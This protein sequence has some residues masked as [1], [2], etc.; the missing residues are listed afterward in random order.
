MYNERNLP[1]DDTLLTPHKRAIYKSPKKK[2]SS[3]KKQRNPST[4][5]RNVRKSKRVAGQEYI[6]TKGI[7]VPEKKV[8][9]CNCLKCRYKCN[10]KFSED[11]RQRIFNSYYSL[12][13]HERQRDFI[14]QMVTCVTPKR[15]TKSKRKTSKQFYLVAERK[16]ERVCKQFFM[17]TLDIGLR[18]VEYAISR[19][20]KCSYEGTDQR[21]K[22]KPSN[23]TPDH[24]LNGVRR[25]IESFPAM[26]S[27]YTR[28]D[29]TKLYLAN[30]LSIKRMYVLYKAQCQSNLL[31]FVKESKYR[32]IF[33]NE[34]NIG[35][36][37]PKKD[38]CALCSKYNSQNADGTLNESVKKSYEEHI[39]NKL[40]AR[41]EKEKDKQKAKANKQYYAAT[42]DLQAVL[43][44][45]CSLI[46]ELYY[47]RKLCCF[48]LS[49]YSL[50][51]GHGFCHMWDETQG[52]RGANE[53]ATCLFKHTTSVSRS[54]EQIREITYYSD[55]CPGQNRNQFVASSHL[56]S[57]EKNP[58]LVKI[59][60]KFL[61]SG[62]SQLECDSIHATIEHAKEN[63]S[64]YVPSQ[65]HTVVSVARRN[66][67]YVVIPMKFND[68]LN[69][70]SYTKSF[71]SNLKTGSTGEKIN[72]M[73]IKWI[74]V[75][76][77]EMT[78]IFVNYT[79]E[80]EKFQKVCVL[81][82]TRKSAS[83]KRLAEPDRCYSSKIPIS[84][85]K[86]K[87]LVNLCSKG[88][89]PEEYKHYYCALPTA[90][91]LKDKVPV[92]CS[93]ESDTDTDE[94]N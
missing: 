45:P 42:F 38:Q 24:I 36:F 25:H 28:K 33:C 51:D 67:P 88:V 9:S 64:V 52:R 14:C 85:M 69:F 37:K 46:G 23:K 89:I 30:N 3:R 41:E 81:T 93:D 84:E 1:S 57:L 75:R 11:E 47:T 87:D 48:N 6:N 91:N 5:K 77:E 50:G 62:N 59:N 29:S 18:T 70:K 55:T 86:K 82:K 80:E 31:P 49:F 79:F 44:T 21:G 27:H 16:R 22:S 12:A 43:T 54:S 4:W 78:A 26:E 83:V 20:F 34:Y 58:S 35:F 39:E 53:I 32:S 71:T 19:Q 74:Q 66:K 65:W 15:R 10:H 13:S 17:A 94:E 68:V 60:H 56:Y 76:K 8:K 63:P 72:W 40:K 7:T 90:K 2:L 73:Q 61:Q 92:P